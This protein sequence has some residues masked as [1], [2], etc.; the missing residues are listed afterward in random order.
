M[1]YIISFC[2]LL[3]LLLFNYFIINQKYIEYLLHCFYITFYFVQDLHVPR[4]PR[5]L[6]R[7]K[8][9][10]FLRAEQL[11]LLQERKAM[12]TGS[13]SGF[14][15]AAAATGA[16]S[17]SSDVG[18]TTAG[19][20]TDNAASNTI[21]L[22]SFW[23]RRPPERLGNSSLVCP[24]GEKYFINDRD[25]IKLNASGRQV[26]VIN[27]NLKFFKLDSVRKAKMVS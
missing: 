22:N 10:A 20:S 21:D 16:D 11:R 24:G 25:E 7:N 9:S 17:A 6:K 13:G 8:R 3:L 4:K 27:K 23:N 1:F 5:F 26:F 19:N 12:L 2:L 18:T 15:N 14:S